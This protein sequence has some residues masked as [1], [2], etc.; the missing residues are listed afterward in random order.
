MSGEVGAVF[1]IARRLFPTGPVRFS[2]EN[3]A[4]RGY[5]L[6]RTGAVETELAPRNARTLEVDCGAT[7]ETRCP[8]R[9]P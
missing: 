5:R 2:A 6:A 8:R 9:L 3:K 1:A 4:A 7:V